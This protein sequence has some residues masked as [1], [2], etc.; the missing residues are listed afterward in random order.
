MCNSLSIKKETVCYLQQEQF[1]FRPKCNLQQWILSFCSAWK[2][3]V[4]GSPGP[5][6]GALGG[7]RFWRTPYR[8][9]AWDVDGNPCAQAGFWL[10]LKAPP[11]TAGQ[12]S[13]FWMFQSMETACQQLPKLWSLA[14]RPVLFISPTLRC[15]NKL[16]SCFETRPCSLNSAAWV[17]RWSFLSVRF[18]FLPFP[19]RLKQQ[20]APHLHHVHHG[21]GLLAEN[22]KNSNTFE[23]AEWSEYKERHFTILYFRQAK[24]LNLL[25]KMGAVREGRNVSIIA[26]V[27]SGITIQYTAWLVGWCWECSLS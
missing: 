1:L 6:W 27:R 5:N 14:Y 12:I 4:P 2:P 13:G 7:M 17:Y 3:G 26:V 11:D 23:S 24:T 8:P 22:V 16:T 21:Y 20:D 15:L 9:C 18:H 10:F 25:F 19:W